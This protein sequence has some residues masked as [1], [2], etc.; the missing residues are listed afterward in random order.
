M[1]T[2]VGT[3]KFTKMY[4]QTLKEY[5]DFVGE[6]ANVLSLVFFLGDFS[7]SFATY[8]G[9][10]ISNLKLTYHSVH[11]NKSLHNIL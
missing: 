7:L 3:Y 6:K 10:T 8:I 1:T 11:N 4:I 5:L 2:I 9:A